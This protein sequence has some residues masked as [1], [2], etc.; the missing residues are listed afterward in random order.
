[1]SVISSWVKDAT[2]QC[3]R[4]SLPI[5]SSNPIT[6]EQL[7]DFWRNESVFL[8]KNLFGEQE[9]LLLICDEGFARSSSENDHTRKDL[10]IIE[11]IGKLPKDADIGVL[12]GPEGGFTENEKNLFK[13]MESN[14]IKRITLGD[15]ILRAETAAIVALSQISLALR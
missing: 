10:S 8:T 12:I 7:F 3:E 5:L 15:N 9:R 1:L 14:Y 13:K 6:L 11:A 2:E 4:L